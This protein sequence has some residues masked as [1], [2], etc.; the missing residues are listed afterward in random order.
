MGDGIRAFADGDVDHI[1]GDAGTSDGGTKQIAAFI[2]G[3]GLDHREDVVAGEILL[4]VTDKTL[5]STRAERL[6]FEAIKFVA[7]A[8]IG[9]ISDDFSVVLFLKPEKEDGGIKTSR[10]GDENFHEA[11]RQA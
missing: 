4:E 8:D 10:V 2:D 6:G 5:G 9:A 11:R 3:T 1:L 7:L